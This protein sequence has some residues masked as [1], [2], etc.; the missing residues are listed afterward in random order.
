[1]AQI[2]KPSE[3]FNTK[4]Y[5]GTGSSQGVTG[6]GFQPDWIWFKCRTQ[7]QNHNLFDAIRGSNKIIQSSTSNAEATSTALLTSFDSD[8]FTVNTDGGTNGSGQTYASWNWL[9]AGTAPS[10]TY[11]VKVVSDGGNKY[12]FDDFGTSAVT[13]EISEGG[14]YT[15]D[16]ADASN[17]GHPIR[18]ST[19]SDGTHGGGSEYTTGVVT[20]GTPGSA[21]AYTRIT[22]AASAPTLYYYC[23][24]HSGM[25]GQANTPTTNSFSN[26]A[27]SI[28]SNISPNTTSGFSVCTYTGNGTSGATFGHGLNSAPEMVIIKQ[29]NSTGNWRV[30]A[31]P[32]DSTFDEVMNLNLTNAK[33]SASSIFNSTAPSSTVVTL[34]NEGDA[35]GNN[36]TFVAYNFHSVKGYSKFGSYTGNGNADGTFVYTGF[37]P[38]F[39]LLKNANGTYNWN[40]QDNKRDTF[41]PVNKHIAPNGSSA[42]A[43]SSSYNVDFLSNGFKLRNSL[44]VW[45]GSGNT[46]I[47]MAF[48]ENPLVGTNNIPT[49]AR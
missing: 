22:V 41:N 1:M 3:Y 37:K 13:L 9:A 17:S 24:V 4:L 33:A 30:G 14:T 46:M 7:N 36:N 49:T 31:T 10:K 39:V 25:G 19:T 48:A 8:G 29:R 27:G 5:S 43:T 44:A 16:Q 18:F 23:S 38:A 12:R 42:E 15:F 32:I 40:M 35:N 34:G 20:N 2:N 6:V 26:F 21:G 47:Y 28:Q 45:N 11:T